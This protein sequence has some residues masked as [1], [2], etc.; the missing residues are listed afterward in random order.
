M[1]DNTSSVSIQTGRRDHMVV[2]PFDGPTGMA[3]TLRRD[4]E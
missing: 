1:S 4:I 3:Y 2:K